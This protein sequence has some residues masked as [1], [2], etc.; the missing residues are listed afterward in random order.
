MALISN[1][2]QVLTKNVYGTDETVLWQGNQG[3]LFTITLSEPATNFEKLFIVGNWND[4]TA[5]QF[6]DYIY[7][8][9]LNA[10]VSYL[11]KG[12]FGCTDWGKKYWGLRIFKNTNTITCIAAKESAW[13]SAS[14]SNMTNFSIQKVIGINRKQTATQEGV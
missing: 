9:P 14:E 3:G 10:E 13:G 12:F 5:S 6:A 11:Q 2:D 8:D 1:G 4:G 7:T